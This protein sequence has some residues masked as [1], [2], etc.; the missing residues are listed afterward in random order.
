MTK[1]GKMSIHDII[2]N[3][4]CKGDQRM[5][6]L[7]TY[8]T[9]KE[10]DQVEVYIQW[11]WTEGGRIEEADANRFNTRRAPSGGVKRLRQPSGC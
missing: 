7:F 2:N 6:E 10:N 1:M 8:T 5:K 3:D 11:W 9:A 4:R